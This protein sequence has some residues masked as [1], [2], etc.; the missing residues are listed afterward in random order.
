VL[1]VLDSR[2]PDP[3]DEAWTTSDFHC[4]ELGPSTYLLTYTL[5]QVARTSRRTTIWRRED[6]EWKILFHQGTLVGDA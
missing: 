3:A 5:Q 6:G 4:R 1:D 2:Q